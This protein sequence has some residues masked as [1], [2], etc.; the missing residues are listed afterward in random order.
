[1]DSVW[2]MYEIG[3]STNLC[4]GKP[5]IRTVNSITPK[6][7]KLALVQGSGAAYLCSQKL[8]DVQQTLIIPN[9][10]DPN[11]KKILYS[12]N[13]GKTIKIRYQSTSFFLSLSFEKNIIR[14]K[15]GF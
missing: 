10:R 15:T 9:V 5:T 6:T 4:N 7:V 1:M 8:I 12:F 2:R 3:I 11:P 14:R 13:P